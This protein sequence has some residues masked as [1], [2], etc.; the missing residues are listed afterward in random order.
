MLFHICSFS[1]YINERIVIPQIAEDW[2]LF[3][4]QLESDARTMANWGRLIWF[5]KN[6]SLNP[7]LMTA[8]E[9][10]A[11]RE[12]TE[13]PDGQEGEYDSPTARVLKG[14]FMFEGT[15]VA[16]DRIYNSNIPGLAYINQVF[17]ELQDRFL[18]LLKKVLDTNI[19]ELL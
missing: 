18:E 4:E 7:L 17:N 12:G 19:L 14:L 13:I 8:G 2:R 10:V 5:L 15:K 1:Y 6:K 9:A 11:Y 16:R 3:V